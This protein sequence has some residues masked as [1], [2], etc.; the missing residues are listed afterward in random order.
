MS[1]QNSAL[2]VGQRAKLYRLAAGF[3]ASALFTGCDS[4]AP[5]ALYDPDTRVAVRVD[6][7]LDQNGRPESR[8]YLVNGRP[9]RVEVDADD[10]GR[11][12]RWEYYGE[13]R[14]VTRIGTSSAMDGREDTWLRTQGSDSTLE[15]STRRDG[16]I[17]RRETQSNGVV[18]R[19][20][21]DANLDGLLDQWVEYSN[22][23]VQRLSIDTTLKAGRPDRRLTYGA[24]GRVERVEE[25]VDGDGQF[26]AVQSEANA[27]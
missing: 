2:A 17:D 3:L 12:D 4:Q 18:V 25:D 9:V 21:Q 15:V 22:G 23:R 7:D 8:T 11:V 10:D 26:E 6:T 19:V 20:E 1:S 27:S 24:D 14:S 16:R 13:D 5:R